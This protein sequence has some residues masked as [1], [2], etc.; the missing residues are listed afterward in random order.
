M[1]TAQQGVQDPAAQRRSGL[2][3]QRP[4]LGAAYDADEESLGQDD[5]F[6]TPYSARNVEAPHKPYDGDGVDRRRRDK[7][8]FVVAVVSN[9]CCFTTSRR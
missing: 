5:P 4:L 1:T 7:P 9:G 8:A 3:E 6:A 2:D